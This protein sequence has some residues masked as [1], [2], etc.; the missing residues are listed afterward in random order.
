MSNTRSAGRTS[1]SR[2]KRRPYRSGVRTRAKKETRDALVN[3][4]LTLFAEKGLDAPSI[5]EI[6][7]RAG[8]SRGAFY[9]QFEDRDSLMVE[10]MKSRRHATLDGFLQMRGDEVSVPALL[11]LF[12]NLVA[13]GS[14]PPKEDRVRSPEFLQ[15]CRRSKELRRAHLELLS[16][17]TQRLAS[18]VRRDQSS[19]VLRGDIDPVS[20][21]ALLVLLEAGME[22]MADVGWSYDVRTVAKVLTNM[23]AASHPA[24]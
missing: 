12:G 16:E 23:V 3:S 15:A 17:T 24:R 11:E 18:I 4:A 7:A 21:G 14:F 9:A 6:C 22:L 8:Y 20:L 13:S 19:G 1:R 2:S 5:D 10:A